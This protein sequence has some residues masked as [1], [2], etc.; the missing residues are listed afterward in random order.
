MQPGEGLGV[1]T[2]FHESIE[3]KED[4]SSAFEPKMIELLKCFP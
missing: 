3:N 2:I 1:L 4:I